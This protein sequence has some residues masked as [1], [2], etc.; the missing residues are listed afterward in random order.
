MS[1]NPFHH[2]YDALKQGAKTGKPQLIRRGK[3]KTCGGAYELARQAKCVKLLRARAKK[4]KPCF[5]ARPDQLNY[6]RD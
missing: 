2:L 3:V 5:S 4:N 6:R 1:D